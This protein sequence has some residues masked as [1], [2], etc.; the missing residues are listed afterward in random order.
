MPV[1]LKFENYINNNPPSWIQRY[2]PIGFIEIIPD[3]D[4]YDVDKYTIQYMQKY[5]IDNVRGG[6]FNSPVLPRHNIKTIE[7]IILKCGSNIHDELDC[8]RP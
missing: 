5:G 2:S 1:N 7:D 6:T 8:L 4:E 3:A